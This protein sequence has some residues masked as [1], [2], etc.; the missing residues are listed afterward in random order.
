MSSSTDIVNELTG[1]LEASPFHA[2]LGIRAAEASEGRVRLEIP[3]TDAQR[4]LQG[5]IHGGLLATLADTA[6]GL[7][8]RTTIEPGR[9]HVTIEMSIHY[10]RPASPGTIGAIGTVVRAGSQIAYAEAD[11]VA[12]D[13]TLLAR[14]TGTYGV[15][16]RAGQ[17]RPSQ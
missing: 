14:A 17:A 2:G 1:R 7:A 12:P 5:T 10:L 13:G 16:V 4:N 15:A 11:V 6:M 9:P 8:V 3:A